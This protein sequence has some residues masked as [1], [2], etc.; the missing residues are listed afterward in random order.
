MVIRPI[1]GVKNFHWK[2]GGQL[3]HRAGLI[4]KN[5]ERSV[6]IFWNYIVAQMQ[7]MIR[8]IILN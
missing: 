3:P 7:A 2:Y 1:R 8:Y 6:Q 4:D 5:S